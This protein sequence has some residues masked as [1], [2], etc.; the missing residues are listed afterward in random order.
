MATQFEHL[1]TPIK[2]GSKMAKNR[3]VFPCHGLAMPFMV[4]GDDDRP[5]IAYQ[6]A[7]AKGG[8]GLNIIGP[9]VCH[10]SGMTGGA[11]WHAPPTPA[12]LL[13]KLRRMADAMH[14]HGTLTLLQL[15]LYGNQYMSLP[16]KANWGF[17]TNAVNP[18][19]DRPEVCHEMNDAEINEILDSYVIYTQAAVESGMDGLEIHA[20]HG[21][22]VQQSWSPWANQR[23]DKW[24]E[25]M[26]F[27]T[28]L[29]NKI[30]KAAGDNFIISVRMTADDFVS[31][32]LDNEANEKIA[33]ALE[34]TGKVDL[35]NVSFAHGGASYRYTVGSMYIPPASISV[36]LTSGIKHAVKSIPVIACSR[37]NEPTLAEK[38][39]ADGHTDMV[40]IV[41]GQIADP[42]FTN[43]ARE[44]KVDE[45]RLCIACNQ[46]CWDS[47]WGVGVLNCTQNAVAGKESLEIAV[48]KAAPKKKKVMVIGGGPGGMEAARVATIRGHEVTLYEKGKQL[49]GQINILGKAPG[50]EEFSQVTR[51][52]SNQLS[53]LG[54][55]IKLNTEVTSE[56]VE[57]EK[58]DAV[59]V[60]T[61]SIPYIEALPGCETS[62]IKVV[63]PS[64]ALNEEIDT[65]NHIVVY[66]CTGLQEGPTVA[67]FLAE[68]G[69]QVDL[70]TSNA[71]IGYYLGLS[72]TGIGTHIPI[73]WERLKRNGVDITTFATVKKIFGR[74]V[75]VADVWSNL[76][77]NI[78]NVDTLI[79]AT[80]YFSNNSLFKALDGKVAELYAIGDCLA[81]KRV[82]NAI[83]TGYL[84]ALNI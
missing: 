72:L 9:L 70:I 76:E 4:D 41:R 77:H 6:V 48:I 47:P 62:G 22:L 26:A 20:C 28:E 71:T 53:N 31:G 33:R 27:A 15:W 43:K 36:P 81:P 25:P 60:A 19:L 74:T 65:G 18:Y 8:C 82:L 52:L 49:G 51:Y 5:Y 84:T 69:K 45:I 73:M 12:K 30:R 55:K 61:G 13:P 67:D 17:T 42:E 83:H 54:V 38:A 14:E 56:T 3:I 63:S 29:I 79:M 50:R 37:I 66:E 7:R 57:K 46:G 34:S 64:Q 1:F 80:G 21:S 24:G 16:D 23:K 68:R 32:G 35:L 59:L 11:I 44:G 75:T 2:I 58:P 39:I 40:G 10:K 78:D